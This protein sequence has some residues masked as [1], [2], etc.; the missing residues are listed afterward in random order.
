MK[1]LDL[2]SA[3]YSMYGTVIIVFTMHIHEMIKE[4]SWHSGKFYLTF[5]ARKIQNHTSGSYDR[6]LRDVLI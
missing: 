4:A 1:L 6:L 2:V 3:M 5:V